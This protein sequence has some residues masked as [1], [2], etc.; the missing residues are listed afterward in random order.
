MID[1][2]NT[3]I[4]TGSNNDDLKDSST[5]PFLNSSLILGKCMHALATRDIEEW[6]GPIDVGTWTTQAVGKWAW[7]SD[8]LGELLMLAQARFESHSYWGKILIICVYCTI[9]H[10]ISPLFLSMPSILLLA[11]LYSPILAP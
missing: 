4:D 1:I 7:S 5:N 8:V 9:V 3:I 6:S 2:I 10:C 11:A